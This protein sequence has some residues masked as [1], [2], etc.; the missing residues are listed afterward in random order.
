MK[1]KII[2]KSLSGCSLALAIL[3]FC[4]SF[5][6]NAFKNL[7]VE[8]LVVKSPSGKGKIFLGFTGQDPLIQIEDEYSNL[9]FELKGGA[10][11]V[12]ELKGKSSLIVKAGEQAGIFLKNGEDKTVGSWT[13]MNDGGAG[14]GLADQKGAAA[15]I[16]RGGVNPSIAFFASQNEPMAAMG[17]LQ[18]VPHLLVSGSS[19]NEGILIHGGQPNSMIV[20]DEIGKVKVL[21]SKHGIFQGKEESN[22]MFKK[23]DGKVFSF[24]DQK[25]LFPEEEGNL[26]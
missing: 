11:P 22:P 20:I 23:G 7:E 10:Q 14:F 3:L 13:V 4:M 17:V 21:I 18:K 9:L 1:K 2:F 5:G 19:G 12:L 24:E 26:R 16:L 6:K 15:T 25:R 8:N